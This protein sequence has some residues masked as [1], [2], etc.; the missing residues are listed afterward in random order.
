MS[1][2]VGMTFTPRTAVK[3]GT[4]N[5]RTVFEA[6]KAQQ[7][8]DGLSRYDSK[9]LGISNQIRRKKW[10]WIGHVL[11]KPRDK[12]IKR[13]CKRRGREEDQ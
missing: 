3:L 7:V 5:V 1:S 11:K 10:K 8:A 6:G 9:L 2:R 4:W 12:V 13:I